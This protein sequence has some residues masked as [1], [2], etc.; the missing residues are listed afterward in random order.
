MTDKDRFISLDAAQVALNQSLVK[1]TSQLDET[2]EKAARG[3]SITLKA[4]ADLQAHRDAIQAREAASE[5][6]RYEDLPPPPPDEVRKFRKLF[7][8][9]VDAKVEARLRQ[10]GQDKG[11]S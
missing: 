2:P 11:S 3:L 1:L 9:M 5:Y 8:K 4:L 6:T 7:N 10:I